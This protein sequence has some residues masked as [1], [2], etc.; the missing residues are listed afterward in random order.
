MESASQ[1]KWRLVRERQEAKAAER[2]KA[3]KKPRRSRR[4][5]PVVDNRYRDPLDELDNL[6][7]SPDY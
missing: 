3:A 5:V 1:K 7:E 2:A 6:G 4:V